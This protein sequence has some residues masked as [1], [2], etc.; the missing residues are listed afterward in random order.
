[1]SYDPLMLCLGAVLWSLLC[2]VFYLSAPE[3]WQLTNSLLLKSSG[4]EREHLVQGFS[5]SSTQRSLAYSVA[6]GIQQFGLCCLGNFIGSGICYHWSMRSDCSRCVATSTSEV[7]PDLSHY[8]YLV[9][10]ELN[11]DTEAI[12]SAWWFSDFPRITQENFCVIS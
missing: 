6:A 10:I 7:P 2:S 3:C 11:F 12:F 9:Y 1:M 5:L 4:L 8:V